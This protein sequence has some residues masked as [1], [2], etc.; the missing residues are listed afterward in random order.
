LFILLGIQADMS[1]TLSTLFLRFALFLMCVNGLCYSSVCNAQTATALFH[2]EGIPEDE[3]DRLPFNEFLQWFVNRTPV[4]PGDSAKKIP[5]HW[6]QF[7]TVVVKDKDRP[8]RIIL[9]R[10][11]PDSSYYLFPYLCCDDLGFYGRIIYT[12]EQQKLLDSLQP[13]TYQLAFL[14]WKHIN[15]SIL[16]NHLE[17]GVVKFKVI[18]SKKNDSIAGFFGNEHATVNNGFILKGDTFNTAGRPLHFPM[19]SGFC[20][21]IR[22]G[23]VTRV[24]E[25][26]SLFFK[27]PVHFI[28]PEE[29]TYGIVKEYYRIEYRFLRP[30]TL[31]ITLDAR[32]DRVTME[33]RTE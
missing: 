1:T 17:R 25:T 20:F 11:H 6:P 24:T 18:N 16:I 19:E 12:P 4:L 13:L 26:D 7:D 22:L 3:M 30:E 8:D 15:D 9:T 10:F 5:V 23:K 33:V 14:Y 27:G 21:D 31:F 28:S 32:T 29:I 2:L